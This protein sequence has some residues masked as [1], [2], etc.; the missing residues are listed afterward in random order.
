MTDSDSRHKIIEAA[1]VEFA[2]KGLAGARTDRIARRAGVNKAMI[3]YYFSSKD[4]LYREVLRAILLQ[5]MELQRSFAQIDLQPRAKL[6]LVVTGLIDFLQGHQHLLRLMVHE[7]LEGAVTAAGL[8]KELSPDQPLP[9]LTGIGGMIEQA[10]TLKL[11]RGN[12]PAQV[13]LH[14]FS[15]CAFYGFFMP[16]VRIMW[17]IDAHEESDFI[18]KR[19]Q[20]I[21]DLLLHGLFTETA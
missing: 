8:V 20:A 21:L 13:G 18:E 6:E 2:D 16:L 10:Q 14:I 1:T 11:I 4:G 19:K 9:Y 15:L 3:H 12:D 17:R 7:L 5:I